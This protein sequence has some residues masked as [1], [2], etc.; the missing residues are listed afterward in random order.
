MLLLRSDDSGTN[1]TVY[2]VGVMRVDGGRVYPRYSDGPLATLFADLTIEE[3]VA[4]L[5]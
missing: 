5:R 4:L 2:G 3:A 1:R